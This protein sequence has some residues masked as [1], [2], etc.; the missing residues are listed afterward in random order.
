MIAEVYYPEA[1]LRRT[2]G[3]R[4]RRN[5]AHPYMI[6]FPFI[7]PNFLYSIIINELKRK[8][9]KWRANNADIDITKSC[10]LIVYPDSKDL[11]LTSFLPMHYTNLGDCA[12]VT[13]SLDKIRRI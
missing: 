9:Y 10:Y 4:L 2:F 7:R 1:E 12:L 8:G 11:L 13:A 3:Y 6:R 5:W